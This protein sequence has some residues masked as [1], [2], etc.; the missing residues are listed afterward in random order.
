MAGHRISSS[1]NTYRVFSEDRMITPMYLN[2]GQPLRRNG[3]MSV[4]KGFP[5]S[6]Q[7]GGTADE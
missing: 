5:N 3:V 6:P 4:S 2:T 1:W 7:H